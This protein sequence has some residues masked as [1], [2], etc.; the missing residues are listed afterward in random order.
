M[1]DIEKYAR[2]DA[3]LSWKIYE[4]IRK[5][6][7]ENSK[8][9][10]PQPGHRFKEDSAGEFYCKDCKQVWPNVFKTCQVWA[11]NPK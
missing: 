9:E 1:T 10:K 11:R 3:L 4:E 8:A 5:I 6:K 7:P 2:E